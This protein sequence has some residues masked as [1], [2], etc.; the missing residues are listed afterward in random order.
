[1]EKDEL[2]RDKE[3]FLYYQEMAREKYGELLSEYKI[4][5]SQV[6]SKSPP[7]WK[8]F[9]YPHK[10]PGASGDYW[11]TDG[12]IVHMGF[13]HPTEGWGIYQPR[14]SGVIAG[15]FRID[16]MNFS[17]EGFCE[18]SAP[19]GHDLFAEISENE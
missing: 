8:R 10:V 6:D 11:V 12:Y 18:V 3:L 15:C 16:D 2:E 5:F 17:V 14:S 19:G 7:A 4:L 9:V 1:M 13:W